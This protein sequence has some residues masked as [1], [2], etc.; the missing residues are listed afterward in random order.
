MTLVFM[1]AESNRL[2]LR[3]RNPASG[4]IGA[5]YA[6][7]TSRSSVKRPSQFSRMVGR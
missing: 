4:S 2:P 6:R 7:M 3:L 1:I 5:A